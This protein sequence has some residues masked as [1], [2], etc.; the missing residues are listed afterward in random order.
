[1]P[2][3]RS[4]RLMPA[5]ISQIGETRMPPTANPDYW[6]RAVGAWQMQ[7]ASNDIQPVGS[8]FDLKS[9]N[10][11]TQESRPSINSALYGAGTGN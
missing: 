2:T 1:M 7:V 11:P 8:V 3:V 6:K 5:R 10:R 9:K 4:T